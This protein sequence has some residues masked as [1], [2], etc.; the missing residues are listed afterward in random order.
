M[1][2]SSNQ[3]SHYPDTPCMVYLHALGWFWGVNGA[4]VLWQSQKGSVWVIL[5]LSSMGTPGFPG[6]LDPPNRH[7]GTEPPPSRQG[8]DH[9]P[10]RSTG[11]DWLPFYTPNLGMSP[12]GS[13]RMRCRSARSTPDREH[14][15]PAEYRLPYYGFQCP[16]FCAQIWHAPS[17]PRQEG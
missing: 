8:P 2:G 13:W 15:S 1:R 10:M 11:P 5:F 3:E 9:H 12:K 14:L 17:G 7:G 6:A 16:W 4:A